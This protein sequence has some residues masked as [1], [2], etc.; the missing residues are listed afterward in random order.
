MDNRTN[1]IAGWVLGS[2]GVA[3][4]LGIAGNMIVHPI[5]AEKAGYPI[6][7]GAEE[8]AGAA[9]A[10]KPIAELSGIFLH[11]TA[12]EARFEPTL[13]A[14]VRHPVDQWINLQNKLARNRQVL[15]FS[16]GV[17]AASPI[18]SRGS[19]PSG[20]KIFLPALAPC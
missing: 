7:G 20:S 15:K 3:L 12:L 1:T 18:V 17:I 19:K 11:P 6:E 13:V 2:M 10:D 4:A 5:K 8:G 14:I 9:A 16:C